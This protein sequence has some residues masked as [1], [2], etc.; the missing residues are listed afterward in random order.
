M[1]ERSSSA[2]CTL[3]FQLPKSPE[4]CNGKNFCHQQPGGLKDSQG[5]LL[6]YTLHIERSLRTTVPTTRPWPKVNMTKVLV[7]NEPCLPGTSRPTS[8]DRGVI[9][10]KCRITLA[11]FAPGCLPA[12]LCSQ[13]LTNWPQDANLERLNFPIPPSDQKLEVERGGWRH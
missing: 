5:S 12:S 1:Q 13:T 9:L 10:S 6:Q 4:R 7:L 3:S 8:R 2:E 11:L